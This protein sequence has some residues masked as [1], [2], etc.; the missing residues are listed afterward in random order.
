MSTDVTA[1]PVD[2]TRSYES[3]ST[4][5][6]APKR[7]ASSAAV[8]LVPPLVTFTAV[9]GVWYFISY[10]IMNENRRRVALPPPHLVLGD[11]IL[12]WE[13]KRGLRPI[14]E[15]MLTTG[16]V[17]ITGLI[18]ATVLG[19][20]IA[21]AMNGARWV[22]SSIFPYAV[23][24]QT[25]PILALVPIIKIW[26]GAG[27]SSRV[28]ACV[29]IAIFPII[30]NALFGLQSTDRAHHELFTLHGAGRFTRLFKL[31]LPGAM[32]AIF[33]GLRI[34]AG[35]CVIGAI[36]G[37]FFF[38]QG[39]IGI[40]RVIDNYQ[41]DNRAPELF[42]AAIVSSLFGIVIF[43]IFGVAASRVLRNWHESARAEQ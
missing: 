7:R 10:V 40:G 23:I 20:I 16:R 38:R 24:I 37:D 29:L 15:S 36:V 4:I 1:Q 32:P 27:L 18:I 14:L 26:F 9:I 35:G 6:S 12:T 43:I 19:L 22:E 5:A 25:L 41:K 42:A 21:I 2:Q 11:G 13:R 8:R 31:E 28:I 34:A 3:A 17:A 30:T 39:A 33:T